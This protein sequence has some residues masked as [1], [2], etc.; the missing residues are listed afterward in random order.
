[1]VSI[2]KRYDSRLNIYRLLSMHGQAIYGF[3]DA[4]GNDNSGVPY[5]RA[6]IR[7]DDYVHSHSLEGRGECKTSR[8][9]RRYRFCP[10]LLPRPPKTPALSIRPR[11]LSSRAYWIPSTETMP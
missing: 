6:A 9:A 1:M 11:V 7:K 3:A 2:S 10:T 8:A 4:V 5:R